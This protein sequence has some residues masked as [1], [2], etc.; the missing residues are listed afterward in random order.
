MNSLKFKLTAGALMLAA[1]FASHATVTGF[2]SNPTTN[3]INWAAAVAAASGT[4]NTNVN[5]NAHPL[6]ALQSNFYLG[7][8]GVTLTAVGDDN[9]VQSGAGPGESN[10]FST[11]L[12]AGE[13]LH[14]FSNFLFDGNA[15][16]S[17][18]ISFATPVLG[19]GLFIIDY[20]NPFDTNPLTVEAFT[21]ANGAGTSLGSF[22]AVAFNHGG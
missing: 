17:L 9:T 13:G 12:S 19:A 1:G 18:T 14:A 16:S 8:D 21:G 11:P 22:S 15:A 3:S 7:S 10:T 4:I 6:G 20:F 2:V 5:F